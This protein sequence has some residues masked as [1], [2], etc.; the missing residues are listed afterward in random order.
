MWQMAMALPRWF[1]TVGWV[2]TGEDEDREFGRRWVAPSNNVL[3]QFAPSAR[4][5]AG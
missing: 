5:A 3:G 2:P 1:I 4:D